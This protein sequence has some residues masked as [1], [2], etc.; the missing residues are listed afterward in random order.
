MG[1]IQAITVQDKALKPMSCPRGQFS[2]SDLQ[3]LMENPGEVE[4]SNE[5]GLPHPC[6]AVFAKVGELNIFYLACQ[7]DL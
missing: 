6:E 3:G 1:E 7:P 4:N 5:P 2:L